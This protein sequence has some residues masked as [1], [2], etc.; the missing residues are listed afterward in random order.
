MDSNV[1]GYLLA[2]R[3]LADMK[4]AVL[5]L[6]SEHDGLTNAEI[7]RALGIYA[8]HIRHEGHISRTLL[9]MLEDDGVV[10]QD[11]A[12]KKWHARPVKRQSTDETDQP[13][14]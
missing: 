6:V 11:Q 7:G 13:S 12:T 5:G 4:G 2:Q 3:A 14:D 1:S 9:A 10:W 8:G